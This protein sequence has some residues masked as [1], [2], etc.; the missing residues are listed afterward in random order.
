MKEHRYKLEPYKGIK[1]RHHCPSCQHN[2]KTFSL[3]I[4]METGQHIDPKV[5]RCNRENNCGYHYTPKQYFQDNNT[6]LDVLQPKGLKPKTVV[7][8]LKP[9]SFIAVQVFKASLKNLDENNFVK[10]LVDLFGVEVAN[11]VV[12]KYFI[13]TSKH[14]NGAT[15]FWQIDLNGKV[16]T[17]KIM[18]YNA[19]NGKRIKEPFSH[20]SWVH[21]VLDKRDYNLQQC[22]FGEHLLTD[23]TKPVAIVESEKTAVIASIYLPQFIWLAVG[24]L[25]NLTVQKC[26][27]L[28]GRTVTLFPDLCGFEKWNEKVM[29]LSHLTSFTVS[30]LLERKATQSEKKQG[31]DLADYLI[32]FDY[33]E[34]ISK[35]IPTEQLPTVQSIVEAKPNKSINHFNKLETPEQE[36]WEQKITELENYFKGITLPTQSV[37]LN[38]FSTIVDVP[39]FI[40]SHFENVKANNGKR[41]FLPYLQRLQGLKEMMIKQQV[42]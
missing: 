22:L 28:K 34:F 12:G 29:E 41:T 32:R 20:I 11:Q 17:G 24:S 31:L 7:P 30:D 8:P 2:D 33:R 14:W 36:N 42:P 15:V 1:T 5:G 25:T 39:Q 23:K 37:K 9:V 13:G 27:A 21:R 38:P 18:L 26:S 19:S 40:E 6:I 10:F 16:R 4:D 35:P 3:Y